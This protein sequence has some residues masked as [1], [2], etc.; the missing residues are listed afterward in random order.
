MRRREALEALGG[1]AAA[2]WMS[3]MARA[4][5]VEMLP[6]IPLTRHVV[7]ADGTYVVDTAFIEKLE[8][9][10]VRANY[11]IGVTTTDS[12]NPRCPSAQ[13]TPEGGK[14]VLSSCVDR[15]AQGEFTFN[16]AD[17]SFACDDFCSKAD[18]DVEVRPTTIAEGG[19]A[20][21][22]RWLESIEGETN[23]A[24]FD[25]M[26]EAFQCYG[27]QGV[28][29]CGHGEGFE[30]TGHGALFRRFSRLGQTGA[31]RRREKC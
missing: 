18:A 28:A 20:K 9:E 1:I 23:V 6:T 2:A 26:V 27:P 4:A 22:R 3:R 13:Y 7:R 14:L 21:P 10:K 11:R 31:G 8:D 19:E 15:V 12:G 17:F 16:D 24:G 5:E 25:S 30:F 29:G